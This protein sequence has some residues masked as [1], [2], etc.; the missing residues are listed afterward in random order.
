[1]ISLTSARAV[2]SLP[3]CTGAE[4]VSWASMV[5]AVLWTEGTLTSSMPKGNIRADDPH[6]IE[7][8]D[9]IRSPG[10]MTKS[11]RLTSGRSETA[12]PASRFLG[13]KLGFAGPFGR[14]VVPTYRTIEDFEWDYAPLP[15]GETSANMIATVA[16]SISSR[17][18]HPEEAW[19]LVS[20]LTGATTQA[21]QAELG[22]AVP[23]NRHGCGR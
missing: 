1:M 10:V 19:Q 11:T 7:V 16:W 17:T 20:W 21:E 14:W 13:G 9:R 12:N 5:R 18:E 8:L 15:R 22:L 23:T 3:D 4:F 6:V 2:G